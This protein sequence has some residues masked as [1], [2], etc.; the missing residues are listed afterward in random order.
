MKFTNGYELIYEKDG[1]FFGSETRVPT[2][3][4]TELSITRE[5]IEG[6]KLVYV[7]DDAILGST[8]GIPAE[9]DTVL[10]SVNETEEEI[11]TDGPKDP[12]TLDAGDSTE[13]TTEPTEPTET[14]SEPE[15]T[16][17]EVTEEPTEVEE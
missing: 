5:E 9:G 7:K 12:G 6:Y 1:K 8:T 16:E 17:P 4:D 14:D 3:T 11:S 15:V 2:D 13:E 10:V